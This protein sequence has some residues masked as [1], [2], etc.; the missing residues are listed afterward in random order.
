MSI[1]FLPGT[2]NPLHK[3]HLQIAQTALEQA[4]LHK[5][6]F[7]LSPRPPHKQ[8]QQYKLLAVKDRV[9]LLEEALLP[10]T[11]FALDLSEIK[12]PGLSYTID[13]VE[14]LQGEYSQNTFKLILG[15]DAFLSLESFVVVS[16]LFLY[17]LT[18]RRSFNNKQAYYV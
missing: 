4:N 18:P 12:R 15:M 13:T 9:K 1:A 16:L 3:A 11:N 2:F 7:V 14:F 8:N 17:V 5:V 10:Y 6:I